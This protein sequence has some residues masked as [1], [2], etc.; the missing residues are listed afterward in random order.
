MWK[1]VTTVLCCFLQAVYRG[2]SLRRKL[3]EVMERA[4]HIS[5]DDA[6]FEEDINMDYVD[7]VG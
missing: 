2:H 3:R 6:S 5:D 1:F 7:E 4:R